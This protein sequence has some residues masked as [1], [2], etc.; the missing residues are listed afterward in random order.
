MARVTLES[1]EVMSVNHV[2]LGAM[3]VLESVSGSL[4]PI[5]QPWAMEECT[6]DLSNVP[7]TAFSSC[8]FQEISAIISLGGRA[9][10][11]WQVSKRTSSQ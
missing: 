11:V 1:P 8:R 6:H 7:F 10:V 5:E 2:S 9:D 4:T 3:F